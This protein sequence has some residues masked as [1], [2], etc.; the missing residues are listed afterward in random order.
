MLCFLPSYHL[1][2]LLH[3]AQAHQA[4]T[5][6]PFTFFHSTL[7]AFG[8]EP[9]AAAQVFHN[10]PFHHFFVKATEQAVERLAFAQSDGHIQSPLSTYFPLPLF[11]GL[12]LKPDLDI[13]HP[14]GGWYASQNT[15][16][17]V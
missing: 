7:F 13:I 11:R 15:F 14:G 8:N 3:L 10:S 1:T 2:F 6:P 5:A 12:C 17:G 4:R 9:A 16:G